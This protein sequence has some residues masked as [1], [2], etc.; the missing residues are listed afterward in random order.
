LEPARGPSPGADELKKPSSR[1]LVPEVGVCSRM[2]DRIRLGGLTLPNKHCLTI[3]TP[4][5]SS[6]I[7]EGCGMQCIVE[8]MRREERFGSE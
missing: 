5:R 2:V 4:K 6:R 8:Y 1:V 3:K 7:N